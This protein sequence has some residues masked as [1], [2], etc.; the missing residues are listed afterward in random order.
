MPVMLNDDEVSARARTLAATLEPVIGQV[1]FSPEAH[2][3]YENLGF[4]PSSGERGGV[5]MPDG[6]AYFTSR[7]SCMGQVPGEVVAAAFAVFNPA[8]VKPC[9]D[10]GWS[11]TDAPTIAAARTR[12]ATA[13]LVR[14]LGESPAGLE[15][16]TELLRRA[17]VGL[18]PEGRPLYAGVLSLDPPGDPMG[19][20]FHVG[21]LLREFRGD[22]HTAA[23]VSAGFDGTEI[24]LLSELFLGIPLRT[25]VRSRAWS[26]AELDAAL[27]RLEARGLVEDGAFTVAGHAAREAVER[28]TD[29]QLRPVVENLGDDN[30]ELIALLSPWGEAVRDAGG[31]I[32]SPTQLAG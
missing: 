23:W 12:G 25:Y 9:V 8:I 14:I 32:A 4:G 5:A 17:T 19:D 2:A 15:R 28:A 20:L 21:D 16:A 6:P 31:Y 10:L 24:G 3:E 27:A 18:R 26:E 7:G 11:L 22:S 13:Q 1:F 29:L 30:A